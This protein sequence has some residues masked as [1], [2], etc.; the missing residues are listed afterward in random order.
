MICVPDVPPLDLEFCPDGSIPQSTGPG[1]IRPECPPFEAEQPQAEEQEEEPQ[2][3]G[4][5]EPDEGQETAGP[6][7]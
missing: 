1:G 2:D 3:D 7:T 6:I 5:E 4:Q